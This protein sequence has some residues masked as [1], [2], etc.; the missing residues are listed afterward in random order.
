MHRRANGFDHVRVDVLCLQPDPGDA[1]ADHERVALQ[2]QVGATT[3][4]LRSPDLTELPFT[5]AGR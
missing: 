4:A 2:A 3:Y 5:P 1:H